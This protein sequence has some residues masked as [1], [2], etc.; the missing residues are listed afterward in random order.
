MTSFTGS[1]TERQSVG[2]PGHCDACADLGHVDAHPDL[3]C[4]DVGCA[5]A[6][7]EPVEDAAVEPLAPPLAVLRAYDGTHLASTHRTPEHSSVP[8]QVWHTLRRAT[9]RSGYA[10]FVDEMKA[11]DVA[12]TGWL[13]TATGAH[14]LDAVLVAMWACPEATAMRA[15]PHTAASSRDPHL[16]VLE[17]AQAAMDAL[18]VDFLTGIEEGTR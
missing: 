9:K 3:G 6:H 7:P 17:R 15:V 4:S 16:T 14:G 2:L 12:P 11:R 1:N 5:S 13:Y 8:V 18:W 10:T